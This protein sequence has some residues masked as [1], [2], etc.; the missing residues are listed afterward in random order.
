MDGY[1][2]DQLIAVRA[3]LIRLASKRRTVNY[4]T[5]AKRLKLD[6]THRNPNDR[7]LLGEMLGEVSVQEY[8][9]GR[10]MLTAIVVRK[11][12]DMPGTGFR[13]LEGFPTSDEFWVAEKKRVFDY[14]AWRKV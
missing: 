11:D 10:P 13:G 8:R 5:L 7:R 14:W 3:E 4:S 6:W 1:S 9:R 12:T 2:K